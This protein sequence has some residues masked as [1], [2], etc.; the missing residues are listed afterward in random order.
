[1][2][3]RIW[4]FLLTTV[5][6]AAERPPAKQAVIVSHLEN[7]DLYKVQH[8]LKK[9]DIFSTV[10]DKFLPS[11]L[12]DAEWPSG[13]SAKLGNTLKV[14]E[15]QDE[16]SI[17][18][19]R[20]HPASSSAT[21]EGSGVTYAIS[22]T[23]PDAPSRDNPEWSEFCHFIA[24]GVE[25][26]SESSDIFRLS[27][28]EDIIPYKPPSPPPKTGKHRYVFLLFAPKNDT[29]DPLHLSKPED[30]KHWGTGKE[31]HGVRDWAEANGLKPVAANFIYAQNEEQ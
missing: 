15:V 7:S 25:V 14:D 11:F 17:I 16:P 29:T 22:I 4:V 3:S 12:L 13:E 20:G 2:R 5:A 9:A 24:T 31:R 6:T 19:H 30:R 8:K 21:G 28:L 27:D 18:V 10:I 23:D 1:M 26:P